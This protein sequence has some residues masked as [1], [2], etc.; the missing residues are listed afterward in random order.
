MAEEKKAK[1]TPFREKIKAEL[2]KGLT[3]YAYENPSD[4]DLITF[5]LLDKIDELKDNSELA[6]FLRVQS[7]FISQMVE[8]AETPTLSKLIHTDPAWRDKGIDFAGISGKKDILD[9]YLDVP[10]DDIEY[11]AAQ[12]EMDPQEFRKKLYEAGLQNKR[13][14]IA[15][16]EDL[17]GWFDSPDAFAENLTGALSSF[18]L[19]RTQEAIKEGKDPSV[20]DVGLDIGQNILYALPYAGWAG[21]ALQGSKM[22]TRLAGQGLKQTLAKGTGNVALNAINPTVMEVAD[23]VAYDEDENPD[24]AHMSGSDIGIGTMVNTFTPAWLAR[25]GGRLKHYITGSENDVGSQIARAAEKAVGGKSG[26]LLDDM[27]DR[28]QANKI[29][30][31]LKHKIEKTGYE[32]LT[33]DEKAFYGTFRADKSIAEM[34]TQG[35][36]PETQ[37]MRIIDEGAGTLL[38]Q[39]KG[40]TFENTTAWFEKTFEDQ[41]RKLVK[42]FGGKQNAL[43]WIANNY[44]EHYDTW[45]AVFNIMENPELKNQVLSSMSKDMAKTLDRSIYRGL[46]N[47]YASPLKDWPAEALGNEITNHV[48]DAKAEDLPIVGP[49][50]KQRKEE[51]DA[52]ADELARQEAY[53]KYGINF[54]LGGK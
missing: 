33:A 25:N 41:A 13:Y 22:A 23:A 37:K 29:W 27:Y 52:A 9:N 28:E 47:M 2:E 50:I 39:G 15:H 1:Y 38:K 31:D 40:N 20:K 4:R 34:A 54:M 45:L 51:E 3:P 6:K 46:D 10:N 24:R 53:R 42:E 8:T 21:K 35:K 32:S 43:K 48:G 17:G 7:G 36:T 19:S 44:P 5:A 14:K 18:L 11:Y 49:I 16:G 12:L 30:L 26:S